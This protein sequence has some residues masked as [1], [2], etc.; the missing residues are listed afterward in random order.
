MLTLCFPGDLIGSGKDQPVKSMTPLSGDE[1]AVYKAVLQQYASEG[2]GMLNVSV[3]TFPLDP[4]PWATSFDNSDCLKGIQLENLSVTAHS[5]HE[6]VNEILPRK[7]MRLVDPAKQSKVVHANDPSRTIGN[8]KS[9]GKAVKDAFDTGLF[10]MSEIAFDNGH[11]YA[12]VKYSF[13]C[14]SLC[15]NG[16]TLIFEKVGDTWRKA[17]RSCGGWVS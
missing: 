11:H 4:S 3:R 15:G 1:I 17:D 16:M 13:C 10:S 12:A 14:G 8:G 6:L 5:F 7:N 9:I 2:S